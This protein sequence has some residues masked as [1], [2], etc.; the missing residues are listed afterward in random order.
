MSHG[1]AQPRHWLW[2]LVRAF[3]GPGKMEEHRISRRLWP[4]RRTLSFK[5]CAGMQAVSSTPHFFCSGLVSKSFFTIQA[6]ASLLHF[7]PLTL[8]LSHEER[9]S[10]LA[11]AAG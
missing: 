5:T 6:R 10:E 1:G 7:L 9:S 2:R 11:V 8:E 4:E 3:Q